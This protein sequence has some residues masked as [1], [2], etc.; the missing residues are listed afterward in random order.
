MTSQLLRAL[1]P[2]LL[3]VAMGFEMS[4]ESHP[5]AFRAGS[6]QRALS[7][8][9]GPQI[10]LRVPVA[11]KAA[12]PAPAQ[13]D[14][15]VLSPSSECGGPGRCTTSRLSKMMSW[16]STAERWLRSWTA[17]T[18]PGGLAACTTSWASSLPTTW[19]P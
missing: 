19:H 16:D 12:L 13:Q 15:S 17:P 3:S 18:H 7:W 1:H 11:Q 2:G 6:S 9:Q 8:Y 14:L 10:L 5:S 4:L